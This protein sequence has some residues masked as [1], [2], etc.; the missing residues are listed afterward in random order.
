VPLSPSGH[1][2]SAVRR[3]APQGPNKRPSREGGNSC[4][5][6]GQSGQN[7][8]EY[9]DRRAGRYALRE[10]ARSITT[11]KSL[12]LCG[13]AMTSVAECVDVRID[14]QDRAFVTGVQT[15]SSVHACP[16]CSAAIREKR[17]REVEGVSTRV[18]GDGGSVVFVTLT[19]SHGRSD[20]LDVLLP[21]LATAW[22][23]L[24]SNRRWRNAPG[25]RGAVKTTE[26]TDGFPNGWHPHV[27]ALVFFDQVL[28]ADQLADFSA[29]VTQS[30]SRSM[31]QVGRAV[32]GHGVRVQRIR[33]V[34]GR[35]DVGE[36]LAKV[37]DGYG[38]TRSVGRE[39]TRT[40]LKKGRRYNR[41]SP[42]ELLELASRGDVRARARWLEYEQAT[43]GRRCLEWSR[44]DWLRALRQVVDDNDQA[45][46]AEQSGGVSVAELSRD[47]WLLIAR[48]KRQ[49]QLLTAAERHGLA[50]VLELLRTLRARH[51]YELA[52]AARRRGR[53]RETVRT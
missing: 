50:G 43:K 52:R 22:H 11:L 40:D 6:A 19:A 47:E 15:C 41:F 13:Y 44:S 8:R 5:T 24:I 33:L 28:T 7:P 23:D 1:R 34:A 9:Q 12:R 21:Q 45:D 29:Y 35:A 2:L 4:D 49:A 14:G 3:V 46:D 20:R 37:Q 30:W 36:Y 38:M 39:M 26:I 18:L 27:H 31:E 10:A 51:A 53:V 48:Y 42:F 17:A 32:N 16:V 25:L